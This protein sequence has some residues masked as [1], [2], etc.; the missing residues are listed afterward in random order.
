MSLNLYDYYKKFYQRWYRNQDNEELREMKE[1][2]Y[3][4]V[5]FLYKNREVKG[6]YALGKALLM[7]QRLKKLEK[8]YGHANLF[9]Y[10]FF[11]AINNNDF[12]INVPAV[13]MHSW[14]FKE[15]E[16]AYIYVATSP[17]RFGESKLGVTKLDPE[18]RAQKY[19]EK[20]MINIRLTKDLNNLNIQDDMVYR[21]YCQY[22]SIY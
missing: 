9:S 12:V 11:E 13:K 19:S 15:G 4:I 10:A 5:F 16:Y 6:K 22:K 18:I 14:N 8:S 1:L 17:E 7:A 2:A 20:Y 21:F 3:Q